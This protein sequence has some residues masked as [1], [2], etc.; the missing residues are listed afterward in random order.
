MKRTEKYER[1]VF[2]ETHFNPDYSVCYA[3]PEPLGLRG[4]RPFD[5]CR[6]EAAEHWLSV[7]V[8][9]PISCV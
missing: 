2:H 4:I 3:L 9:I 1:G 7:L 8:M 5:D 6:Y